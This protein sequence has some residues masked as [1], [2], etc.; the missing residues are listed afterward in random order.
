MSVELTIDKAA[1]EPSLQIADEVKAPSIRQKEVG[2]CY[3]ILTYDAE[4]KALPVAVFR[5]KMVFTVVEFDPNAKVEE[6]PYGD[7]FVLPD[8]TISAKDYIAGKTLT[9][10]EFK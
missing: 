5:A 9:E 8:V 6:K 4:T 1:S 2:Y 10:S 7:E 3:V